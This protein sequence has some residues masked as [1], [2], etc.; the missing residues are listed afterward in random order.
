M[1]Y[2]KGYMKGLLVKIKESNPSRAS[3]FESK[4]Q[5]FV[6]SVLGRFD[7]Y[8]FWT[9]EEMDTEGMVILSCYKDEDPCEYFY[10][11]KDGLEA[12]KV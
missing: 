4:I 8:S 11:F 9:G 5:G 12:E 2:I 1:T 3:V 6:K 10:F 7:E